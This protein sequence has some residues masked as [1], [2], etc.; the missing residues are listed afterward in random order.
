MFPALICGMVFTSCG[1]K[2]STD[3]NTL[4]DVVLTLSDGHTLNLESMQWLDK[5]IYLSKTD[6]TMNYF[7]RIWL[8][9]FM[10]QDIF[11]T[12]M[13]LG[14]GGVK[15]YFFDTSGASI[16]VKGHEQYHN[17]FIEAFAGKGYAFVEVD[18]EDLDN[19]NQYKINLDVVVYSSY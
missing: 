12:D 19:Y 1:S 17:P 16:I 6:V 3:D 2:I 4:N 7:G 5:L 11:V 13:M 15:Y 10:G 9:T 14:S 8:D 18:K